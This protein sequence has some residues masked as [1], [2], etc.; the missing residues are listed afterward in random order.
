MTSHRPFSLASVAPSTAGAITLAVIIACATEPTATI[1]PRVGEAALAKPINCG[2]YTALSITIGTGSISS[3]GGAYV[4]G[5]DGVGAHFSDVNG[6]LMLTV[7]STPR[8]IGWSTTYSTGSSSNRLYT[9][10]HTNPG[11][12]N[13]CGLDGMVV[14]S[15][16][17]AVLTFELVQGNKQDIVHFGR[18]CTGAADASTRVTTSHPDANTWVITG[19]SGRHCKAGSNG[20]YSQAGSA[21]AFDITIA[22]Q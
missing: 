21:G 13:A 5:V 19:T 7:R 18:T 17:S 8:T 10:S 9:N 1:A 6:N 4:E 15:T 16:G 12:D 22:R 2:A 3:D 20:K 14:G 11:G